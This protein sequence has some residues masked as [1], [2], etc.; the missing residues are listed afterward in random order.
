MAYLKISL[1]GG[2]KVAGAL[3]QNEA[4]SAP[5]DI[6]TADGNIRVFPGVQ[7]VKVAFEEL[8][9]LC[10]GGEAVGSIAEELR[11]SIGGCH[12]LSRRGL[13]GRRSKKGV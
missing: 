5:F 9:D 3:A 8:L 10:V 1:H 11:S 6:L 7:E 2:G 12:G 4:M 13:R